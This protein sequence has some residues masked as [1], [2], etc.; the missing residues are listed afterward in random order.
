MPSKDL[1]FR[2]FGQDVNAS[3]SMRKLAVQGQKSAKSITQAFGKM[4]EYVTL[5]AVA[6]AAGAVAMASSFQEATTQ[7]VTG[8]GESE[9]NLG[10]VRQ[11]LLD[12]APAVGIGPTALAKAMFTVESAGYHGAAGL[13]VMKAAA[14]GA[15]IGGADATTVANGLTTALTDYALPAKQAADVTSKLVATVA[16]GKTN[17]GDLSASLSIVAPSAAAA[18]VSLSQLLGAMATMTGEGVSADES[19]QDLKSS[20]ASLQNPT[21]T[22]TQ[23]MAQMGLNSMTVAK[24]LGK[25]GLTGTFDQLAQSVISHMGPAGLVLQSS[26]NQ[27]KLAAQS[28]Q[29]ELK[30]MPSSLQKLA[31]GYLNG[32]ITQEQWRTDMKA[33][34]ALLANLGTQFA[35]TVATANGFSNQL[36]AGGSTASTFNGIMSEMTGGQTGLATALALTGSHSATF[37]KNV[38]DIS[39]ASQDA[40]GNVKGWKETQEDLAQQLSEAGA[41]AQVLAVNVGDVLLPWVTKIVSIGK[42]WMKN[43]TGNKTEIMVL[44]G[45]VGGFVASMMALY[46]A[47]KIMTAAQTAAKIGLFA[48]NTATKIATGVQTAFNAVMD[49]NPIML[50]VLGIAALVAGLVWFFTQTKLGKAIWTD[51]TT[52]IA[53]EW[54]WVA[55]TIVMPS[56]HAVGA[57]FNWLWGSVIKPQGEMMIDGWHVL[58]GAASTVFGGIGNAIKGAFADVSGVV[59]AALNGA[60]TLI[61]GAIGGINDLISAADM[62]PGVHI[63]KVAAIPH[64]ATGVQNFAGGLALVGEN[65][66]EIVGLP[67]GSSVWPNGTG[68]GGLGGSGGIV[69]NITGAVGNE[70]YLAQTVKNAIVTAIR[71]GSFGDLSQLQRV[72]GIS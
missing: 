71:N 38:K 66:P 64:F 13:E 18:H 63:A 6:A 34:P 3:A 12:M 56:V 5:G 24:N 25:E 62:I 57:V 53:A 10:K 55:N 14:E 19:A 52:G 29:Q 39:G 49:A 2:L 54:D 68:P 9:K 16:A 50:V 37:T 31:Q 11:G 42:D 26:F 33:Q 7:L 20:I 40:N 65:G 35:S 59:A 23:A 70:A 43:L 28:V 30:A 41:A 44:V 27:S 51:F 69:I 32:T 36:K 48:W 4:P 67:S 45:V 47:Q 8:A 58:A 72:L 46:A 60:I 61:D 17:M 15:K 22:Q 1:V 21:S